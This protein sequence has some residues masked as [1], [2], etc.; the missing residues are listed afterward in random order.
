MAPFALVFV[1]LFASVQAGVTSEL[2]GLSDLLAIVKVNNDKLDIQARVTEYTLR[3]DVCFCGNDG[4][5]ALAEIFSQNF[6]TWAT[7]LSNEAD[8]TPPSTGLSLPEVIPNYQSIAATVF[9]VFSN[10]QVHSLSIHQTGRSVA[11][12]PIYN[13][14]AKFEQIAI[15]QEGSSSS[16]VQIVGSYNFDFVRDP[17]GVMK[18]MRF[19]SNNQKI[20]PI[21][22]M[23]PG[24]NVV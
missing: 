3:V 5:S 7:G 18:M 24:K 14:K 10:H 17:N 8:P 2:K 12:R 9:G 13:V 4:F 11:E 16:G 23:P 22:A 19:F 6:T 15:M 20:I 1:F 21:A